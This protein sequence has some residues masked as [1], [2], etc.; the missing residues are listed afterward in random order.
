MQE[1]EAVSGLRCTLV[2]GA[3]P[4]AISPA[5]AHFPVLGKARIATE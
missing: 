5:A 4:V 2:R 1:I 3:N